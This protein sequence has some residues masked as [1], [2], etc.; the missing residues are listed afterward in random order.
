[1]YSIESLNDFVKRNNIKTRLR[2]A[3]RHRITEN[4]RNEIEILDL[5]N[6]EFSFNYLLEI[7]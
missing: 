4:D 3:V 5:Y 2:N 7:S 1:M 6:N